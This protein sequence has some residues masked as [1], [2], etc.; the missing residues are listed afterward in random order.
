MSSTHDI[1]AMV[2]GKPIVV[3]ASTPTNGALSQRANGNRQLHECTGLLSN[4]PADWVASPS[5]ST[6]CITV[7]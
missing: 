3:I 2:L 6:A 4:G 7:G 1:A 5:T